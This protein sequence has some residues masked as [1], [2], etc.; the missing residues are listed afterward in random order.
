MKGEWDALFTSVC[1]TSGPSMT[2]MIRNGTPSSAPWPLFLALGVP[3]A[4]PS[5]ACVYHSVQVSDVAWTK[6]L[7]SKLGV[8]TVRPIYDQQPPLSM[9]LVAFA[10]FW[11]RSQLK[12]SRPSTFEPPVPSHLDAD[13]AQIPSPICDRRYDPLA[14]VLTN[15]YI[16]ALVD[17]SGSWCTVAKRYGHASTLSQTFCVW[18][19]V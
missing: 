4:H 19:A 17:V 1:F 12:A 10:S 2:I 6:S 7:C 13:S 14:Y 5:R 18:Y 8:K 16:F 15:I 9:Y 11:S 3:H